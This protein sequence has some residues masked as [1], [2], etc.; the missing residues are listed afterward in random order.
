MLQ[1]KFHDDIQHLWFVESVL[2]EWAT[3]VIFHRQLLFHQKLQLIGKKK[4][5]KKNECC[6]IKTHGFLIY[7]YQ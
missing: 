2:T 1:N 6:M 3:L 7:I 4:T 5:R